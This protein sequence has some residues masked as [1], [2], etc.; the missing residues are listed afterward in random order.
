MRALLL[1]LPC[2]AFSLACAGLPGGHDHAHEG[3]GHGHHAA[4][5]PRPG[6][7][8]TLYQSGL[9]LF[10]EYP[11][12]VAGQESPLV[13]HFT[14]ARDPEAFRWVTEGR[15]TATLRYAD[16][17][18]E[19]FVAEKLLRNGIFKPTVKPG[20][21]GEATLTLVLEGPVA[22]TVEVGAVTVHAT[23]DAA[24]AA[25]APDEAAGEST[26]GYLK[27]SQ[28]KTEYATAA[29]VQQAIRGGVRA[30]GEISPVAGRSAEIVA[31]VAGRVRTSGAAP[32]VGLRVTRGQALFSLLPLSGDAAGA[33]GAA[34]RAAAALALTEKDLARAEELHGAAVYSQK[35]L[36]AA[37]AARDVAASDLR[38]ADGQRAAWNGSGGG[39]ALDIRSPLDG[40]VAFADVAPGALV[41]AGSRLLSIV[42]PTRVWLYCHVTDTD[43]PKVE[44]SPGAT[45]TVPGF[46]AP[47]HV[48]GGLVAIGAAVDPDSRTVP[49]IFEIDNATGTLKPGMFAKVTVHTVASVEGVVIPAEAVVDDGGRPTVYVMDGG[50]S[51]FAR[52]VKLG[53][54]ADGLVQVLDGVAAGERVVSRG[55][56]EIKLSTA[57]GA[58]PEHG[59][60]H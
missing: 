21:A 39:A 16:G 24:V 57:G 48:E 9:E 7:T 43:A 28:W 42:D 22:G 37:R 41:N 36:D 23:T 11:S 47:F 55:A 29:A 3:D 19:R 50:E 38:A 15:V 46:D 51:F 10:M 1:L 60:A 25:A 20:K 54:R 33:E 2:S 58:I 31:P 59:H 30:S 32:Y 45:F 8:V 44:G 4:E 34:S 6:L 53:A 5:D 18:E 49:V 56:Y 26:V 40:V 52:R 17:T 12:L 14:D 27:E 13:A 35:Q